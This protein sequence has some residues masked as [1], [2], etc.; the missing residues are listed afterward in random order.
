MNIRWHKEVLYALGMMASKSRIV[1]KL[2]A[3]Y[4]KSDDPK[5][6]D[7]ASRLI[8]EVKAA[9]SNTKV[10]PPID[11]KNGVPTASLA[12]KYCESVAFSK[13]DVDIT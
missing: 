12:A 6:R 3:A 5:L 8:S 2:N 10:F 11:L 7:L 4:A 1:N 9:S 13:S